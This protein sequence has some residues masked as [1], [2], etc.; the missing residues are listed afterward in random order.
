MILNNQIQIES[1]SA[2]NEIVITDLNGIKNQPTEIF[3]I[4][5]SLDEFQA[6]YQT[7]DSL[8][9]RQREKDINIQIQRGYVEI[10][11]KGG[12]TFLPE[13]VKKQ[14]TSLPYRSLAYY[15]NATKE[16]LHA[17]YVLERKNS[18]GSICNIPET[19]RNLMYFQ[20]KTGKTAST[21][22]VFSIQKQELNGNP[23]FR[24][25]YPDKTY[26]LKTNSR[27]ILD[28]GEEI[29]WVDGVEKRRTLSLP[30]INKVYANRPHTDIQEQYKLSYVVGYTTRPLSPEQRRANA[31]AAL[32]K[33]E[34][35]PYK[36]MIPGIRTLESE[37][38]YL[39]PLN[40]ELLRK[41]SRIRKLLSWL[42]IVSFLGGKGNRGSRTS[43]VSQ[44]LSQKKLGK[45]RNS[46]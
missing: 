39:R 26:E 17:A 6:V 41:R 28:S 46:R 23:S 35:S 40:V 21:P 16:W 7:P 14:N 22:C 1:D 45:E 2:T 15:D 19:T 34:L 27:C 31:S 44:K 3:R 43:I 29:T 4:P 8:I 10:L 9:L 5:A 11:D 32:R 42:G 24:I 33:R 20:T 18:V 36:E 25:Q 12:K 30:E 37:T 38:Q 13:A